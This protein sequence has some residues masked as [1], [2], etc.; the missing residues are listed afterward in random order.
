[1]RRIVGASLKARR[2]IAVLTAALIGAGVWQLSATRIDALPE[3]TPTTVR[4]QTEAL[5]LSA[6]EVEQLITVPLEQDLLAG[7]PFLTSMRSESIPGLSSIELIFEPNTDLLK[8]RQVVQERLTQAAGLPNV[9]S[10]P[11]MLQPLAST[12]RIM[13]IRLSSAT[14][15]PIGL[16]VLA[17]WT[18]RPALL[19]VPGVSNVSIWG[20]RERQLQVEVDPVLLAERDVSLQDVI[21]T[22]GNAL[23]ASPLTFL[24]ANTP[25]TGGF[26]DTANQRL[27]VQH[28]QPI[29]TAGDL[30]KV[31]IATR[32]GTTADLG[33][34]ATVVEDHQPLIGDAVFT[35]GSQG[36]L[37]VVDK[38]PDT[39]TEDVTRAIDA[40]L[41][42][43]RPGLSGIEVDASFYRPATYTERSIG[44]SGRSAAISLVL[45][46]V[47]LA[48]LSWSWRMMVIGVAATLV[49][50][51]SAWS[52]LLLRGT[53]ANTMV[54][55]GLVMAVAAVVDDAITGTENMHRRLREDRNVAEPRPVFTTVLDASVELRGSLIF[56]LS[57]ALIAAV[58]LLF[59]QGVSSAL[60]PTI[61]RTY[62]LALVVS[63]IAALIVTPALG[64]LLLAGANPDR[65]APAAWWLR[66]RYVRLL[67]SLQH[68][69][70]W[71]YV[72]VAIVTIVA[73][74]SVP[75]MSRSTIPSFRDGTVLVGLQAAAGTSLPEMD[76]ITTRV[77]QELDALPG[78]DQVGSH[79]G[80]AVSSDQVVGVDAAQLWV[81][82][83]AS[84]DYDEAVRSIREVVGGYPGLTNTVQTYTDSRIA[85]AYPAQED[86]VVVRLYGQDL[87][88][89]RNEADDVVHAI[90]GVHGIVAP[91]AQLEPMEPSIDVSVDL[92]ATQRY[93][94]VPG[95][96]RRSASTLLS[97]IGVGSLFEK[98]KVFDVVVWG[99]PEIRHSLSS[100]RN[101]VIDTPNGGHVRLGQVADVHVGAAPLVIR[102]QDDSRTLDVVAGVDGR[103][104]GDV[105]EDV[106]T[107]LKGL[108]FPL[109]Y[110]AEIVSDYTDRHAEGLRGIA[111][112]I[113]V[114]IAILLLLQATFSS[115]RLGAVMFL[116]LVVSLAG[117]ALAIAVTGGV[118]S[119]G[120]IV[121]MAATLGIAARMNVPLVRRFQELRSEGAF[122]LGPALVLRGAGERVI[123]VATT[124][125]T[126][127]VVL[128]PWAISSGP[129]AEVVQPMAVA[130]LGGLIA[131]AALNL[132]VVP[133]LYLRFGT[134]VVDD[135]ALEPIVVVP[136]IQPVAGG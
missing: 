78:V 39:N 38:F 129:G 77:A 68:R 122:E 18:L 125:A 4:V 73:L 70:A 133:D 132:L 102:H 45:L 55:V 113:A 97:G 98:Q 90:A 64:L 135:L 48:L 83:D 75:F 31:P 25:G 121:G 119:L 44:G 63:M 34:I 130:L 61:G 85:T 117:C 112:A 84:A 110:H 114:A 29:T 53:T 51:L 10:T 54:V 49:S 127:L 62:A 15:S 52:I 50:L 1:M 93:G 7:V 91:H 126:A 60:V 12:S 67:S 76:R 111:V 23:W 87:D 6:P 89:L 101:V 47:V 104:V 115:W 8:A 69:P 134:V 26:I 11:Q 21:E 2:V 24:E 120:S 79:I 105:T 37:L 123:A 32:G 46:I 57:I 59:M 42:S 103:S 19:G 100:V 35:D 71:I 16:S 108:S 95:D 22:T 20:Q 9:S 124:A 72:G 58:P 5:G 99:T 128:L 131:A 36:I 116:V 74:A 88:T 65:E 30:A 82:V 41:A 86:P 13:M 33:D 3:F 27:T 94:V 136:E 66:R 17:R 106:R 28:L 92:E 109:E 14:V 56:A 118:V 96:V 43:M 80:R 107:A 81:R 40:K